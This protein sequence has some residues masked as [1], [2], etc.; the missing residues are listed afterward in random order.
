MIK[1]FFF[2]LGF[3]LFLG[4][5]IS[6]LVA[7]VNSFPVIAVIVFGLLFLVPLLCVIGSL[8]KEDLGYD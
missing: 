8:V 2:G 3:V 5:A 7:F 6:C 4:V 1:N